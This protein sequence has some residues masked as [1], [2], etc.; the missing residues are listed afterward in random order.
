LVFLSW[1]IVSILLLAGC[2]GSTP[3]ADAGDAGA[4]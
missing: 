2:S 1:A 4:T 3:D